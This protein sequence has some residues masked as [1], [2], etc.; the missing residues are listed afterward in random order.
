M[1]KVSIIIPIYNA[2]KFLA[3]C[4]ESVIN[5]TY[6]NLEIILVDDGSKDDSLKICK[7][8]AD[9]D[10]R[11]RIF[12]DK[13]H[14]VSYA[15]NKGLKEANGEYVLFIDSDDIVEKV[16]V[17]ELMSALNETDYDIVISGYKEIDRKNKWKR[18][19]L[20]S[21]E[22]EKLLTGT[23][24]YDYRIL[25][26]YLITPWIKLYNMEIIRKYNIYFNENFK[27]AEDHMFNYE[28]MRHVKKYKFINKSLYTYIHQNDNKSLT[29]IKDKEA[30]KCDIE[31]LKMRKKFLFDLDITDKKRLL[32]EWL[33]VL[34]HQYVFVKEKEYNTFNDY[35]KRIKKLKEGIPLD[36]KVS[37]T[38]RKLV[39]FCLRHNYFIPIY[40]FNHLK[41]YIHYKK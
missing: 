4:I 16:Y 36:F 5:Q 20:I 28:Y 25:S 29:A 21:K 19:I 33:I 39:L 7:D 8:Y 23:I 3:Q 24:K 27:I 32:G 35:K 6:K 18:N 1:K 26:H 10:S 41:K 34:S 22:E 15:R 38:K 11:I 14:G 37:N 17:D 31:C 13:N 30:F 2:E 9:K 40:F 12:Y